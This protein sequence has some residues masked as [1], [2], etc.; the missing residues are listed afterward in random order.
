[1]DKARLSKAEK[2]IIDARKKN[3]HQAGKLYAERQAKTRWN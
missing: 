3:I 1:M 2:E